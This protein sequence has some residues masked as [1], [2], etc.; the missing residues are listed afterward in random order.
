MHEITSSKATLIGPLPDPFGLDEAR[1]GIRLATAANGT[2][3]WLVTDYKLAREVLADRRFRR[4]EASEPKAP[5]VTTHVPAAGAMISVDGA[6]HAR[7]RG[8]VAHAHMS[9]VK[10]PRTAQ[11]K[12]GR[13]Q[14]IFRI[15]VP[16]R[17]QVVFSGR[18]MTFPH[19]CYYY[20]HQYWPI[21]L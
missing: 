20:S 18:V 7:V 11:I 5:K 4:A 2:D 15:F 21:Y 14:D 19:A 10:N 9:G 3:F 8:L 6:E 13:P 12:K 16:W 17:K 1:P